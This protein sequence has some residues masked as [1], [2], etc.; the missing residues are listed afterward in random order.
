MFAFADRLPPCSG[1]GA[2][3]GGRSRRAAEVPTRSLH[4]RSRNL[5]SASAATQGC[6]RL[7]HH[8]PQVEAPICCWTARSLLGRPS[9]WDGA[10]SLLT[11]PFFLHA[12]FRAARATTRVR[13]QGP[14]ACPEGPHPGPEAEVQ[15]RRV[16]REAALRFAPTHLPADACTCG[17]GLPRSRTAPRD[18]AT[19]QAA[20]TVTAPGRVP[21]CPPP[22]AR[23]EPAGSKPASP[24]RRR[25]KQAG[26]RGCRGNKTLFPRTERPLRTGAASAYTP[27]RGPPCGC[28]ATCAG[29]PAHLRGAAGTRLAGAE[30]T[31]CVHRAAPRPPARPAAKPSR[32]PK[33]RRPRPHSPLRKDTSLPGSGLERRDHFRDRTRPRHGRAC[34]VPARGRERKT[35]LSPAHTFGSRLGNFRFPC[36]EALPWRHWSTGSDRRS[37]LGS[38]NRLPRQTLAPSDR[39]PQAPVRQTVAAPVRHPQPPSD[40]SVPFRQI[41]TSPVRH[42]PPS[43]DRHLP[44]QTPTFSIRHP[45]PLSDTHFPH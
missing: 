6:K 27:A 11:L 35:G 31:G 38:G 1:A 19:G 32:T 41:A 23:K 25:R 10:V 5:R 8:Q 43:S 26:P 22:R 45:P 13:S 28:P 24:A 9:S 42:P 36:E 17:T 34:A 16:G 39:H 14:R 4:G 3:P 2:G 29:V 33:P 18:A 15:A 7:H 12:H 44:P 20:V 30:R 40:A 21:P 37:P